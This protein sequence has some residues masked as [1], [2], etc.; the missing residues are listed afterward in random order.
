[1]T[2]VSRILASIVIVVALFAGYVT[3]SDMLNTLGRPEGNPMLGAL[4]LIACACFLVAFVCACMLWVLT[5]I[6]LRLEAKSRQP[7]AVTISPKSATEL[8]VQLEA[9]KT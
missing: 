3:L 8:S 9:Q 5:E 4:L 2:A 1:M 7:S 6:A